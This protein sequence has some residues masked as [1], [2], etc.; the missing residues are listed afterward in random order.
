MGLIKPNLKNTRCRAGR[1]RIGRAKSV[2]PAG[3]TPGQL[4]SPGMTPCASI[5]CAPT[6][7][8]V[9]VESHRR[10]LHRQRT[11]SSWRRR[12]HSTAARRAETWPTGSGPEAC[13]ISIEQVGQQERFLGRVLTPEPRTDRT[14]RIVDL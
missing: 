7:Q 9:R 2:S 12:T 5:R 8:H 1:R 11:G 10:V 3:R 14:S 6:W 4:A 13:Q